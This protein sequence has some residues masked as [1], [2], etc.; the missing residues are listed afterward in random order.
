MRSLGFGLVLLGSLFGL[1]FGCGE[2]ESDSGAD[3]VAGT[4]VGGS[5]SAGNVAV[6]GK[7]GASATPGSANGGGNPN[8]GMTTGGSASGGTSHGGQT[9][10]QAGADNAA[11]GADGLVD[12][13]VRKVLCKRRPPEC[14]QGSVPSVDVN[15]YGDCVKIDQCACSAAEQCPDPNQY[16]CWAKQHCGPF[17][18]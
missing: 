8:G 13:D 7:A 2:S 5:S 9:G 15:C 18:R 4:T 14:E 1:A 6:A 17:V 3:G 10:A 12:C 11:G 16:T